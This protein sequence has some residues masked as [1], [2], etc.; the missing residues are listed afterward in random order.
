MAT[1]VIEVVDTAVKIGL[2]GLITLLGTILVTKLNH[3]HENSKDVRKRHFDALESVGSDI[4]EMTHVCLRYWALII[5]WARNAAQDMDLT[6]KRKE[7]LERT[8]EDLF[9]QFKSLTV[10]RLWPFR[11]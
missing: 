6:E 10:A 5:E 8:K 9:N 4:E 2:G 11:G 7:E 3:G 1:T